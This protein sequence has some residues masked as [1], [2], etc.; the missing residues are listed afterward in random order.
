MGVVG[1]GVGRSCS[2]M[3]TF[4]FGHFPFLG[5]G[6]IQRAIVLGDYPLFFLNNFEYTAIGVFFSAFR[7]FFRF[8]CVSHNP[9]FISAFSVPASTWLDSA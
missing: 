7:S 3:A 2:R 1:S 6:Y 4:V 8:V 5:I 9:S